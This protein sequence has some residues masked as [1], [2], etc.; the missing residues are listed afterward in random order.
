MSMSMKIS[1]VVVV[2]VSS[3]D[4]TGARTSINT[5]FHGLTTVRA[6]SVMDT[7]IRALSRSLGPNDNR[8]AMS[9]LVNDTFPVRY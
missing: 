7:A 6:V 4:N 9:L 8:F 5:V 1:F 2:I 3:G